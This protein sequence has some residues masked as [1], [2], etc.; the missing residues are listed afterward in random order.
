MS[1]EKD[2]LTIGKKLHDARVAKGYT[3]DDLQKK[4]QDSKTLFNCD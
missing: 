1:D 3:L 2:S 4:Y